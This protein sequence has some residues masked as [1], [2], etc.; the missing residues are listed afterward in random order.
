MMRGYKRWLIS[1]LDTLDEDGTYLR[2]HLLE[3]AMLLA[4]WKVFHGVGR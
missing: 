4:R 1:S 3:I 2:P